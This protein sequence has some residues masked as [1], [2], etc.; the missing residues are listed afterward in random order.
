MSTIVKIIDPA[1]REGT[2]KKGPWKLM[3]VE[4]SNGNS[5]TVF[6]P[7]EV[8]DTVTESFNDQYNSY[9]YSVVKHDGKSAYRPQTSSNEAS[10]PIKGDD[11]M[12]EMAKQINDIHR[13][14][15]DLHGGGE[16]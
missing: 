12:A 13:M 5:G 6:A 10:E 2:G 4:V 14:V 7:A 9:S 3:K 1:F 8:G 11:P 15:K 16:V